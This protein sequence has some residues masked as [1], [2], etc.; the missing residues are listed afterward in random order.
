MLR[1][2]WGGPAR[3]SPADDRRPASAEAEVGLERA[4]LQPVANRGEEPGRI[5]AV[6][7]A[8]VIG[9]REVHSGAWQD[10]LAQLRV[11]HHRG[12]L[13]HATGAEDANLRLV[14][15]RGVEERAPAAG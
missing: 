4:V 7:Q 13:D 15:D 9:E 11:L 8:V 14:D 5:G 6:D 12:A 1:S 2:R 10:H 3:R